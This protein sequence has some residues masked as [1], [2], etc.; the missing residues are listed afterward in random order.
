MVYGKSI[1]CLYLGVLQH[2]I[3]PQ[4]QISCLIHRWRQFCGFLLLTQ[5]QWKLKWSYESLSFFPFCYEFILF[6]AFPF[7]L[8]RAARR[9]SPPCT[10]FL[11]IKGS[12]SPRC[13]N[14]WTPLSR[15][16]TESNCSTPA[17]AQ[18]CQSRTRDFNPIL[19]ETDFF[20]FFFNIT[21]QNFAAEFFSLVWSSDERQLREHR[22]GLLPDHTRSLQ[23]KRDQQPFIWGAVSSPLWATTA[24]STRIQIQSPFGLPGTSGK[25]KI[26][27]S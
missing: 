6:L 16:R 12:N 9:S 22:F 21:N 1:S 2:K 14:V 8:L 20:N 10:A 5:A 11:Q 4:C 27:S 19:A 23:P 13:R 17:S 7:K 15:R 24:E 3:N 26:Y 18:R 25:N